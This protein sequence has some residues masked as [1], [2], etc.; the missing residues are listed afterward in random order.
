M[1]LSSEISWK[2]CAKG[3]SFFGHWIEFAADT[4]WAL[5]VANGPPEGHKLLE[6]AEIQKFV[7]RPD[8]RTVKPKWALTWE[9]WQAVEPIA[10]GIPG[11][12]F[13]AM[14]FRSELDDAYTNGILRAVDDCGFRA[15][16]TDKE[17]FSEKIC[18]RIVVEIRRAQFVI[19]D[20]TYQRGG[21]YFEA[22][23]ALALGRPVIWSCR[24]DDVGHLH[25]DTRQ[26][27]HIVWSDPAGLRVQ[28]R[29]R[30]RALVPGARMNG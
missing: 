21:V 24:E 16:R 6:T 2:C 25:F 5:L 9:G 12:G 10:G 1:R 4:D 20:F 23:Y 27:P 8:V 18:D 11:L 17:H 29:E 15:I 19:A 30:L 14:A 3:R 22:G 7:A 28:I 13:V 26:Y